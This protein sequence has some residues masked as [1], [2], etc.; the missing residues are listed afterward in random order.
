MISLDVE[1]HWGVRDKRTVAQYERNLRGDREAVLA[2]LNAFVEV[3]IPATW[4]VVGFLFCDGRDE[5]RSILPAVR[6]NYRD[7]HLSPYGDI[8]RIGSDERS[9]PFH[10]APSLIRRIVEAP[11]Q[12][13]ATHTL[14]HY[15][16]LAPGGTL[17][18][19]E[20]DLAAAIELAR[21]KF[22]RTIQSIVFPR[23]QYDHDHLVACRRQNI[24]AYRGNEASWIYRPADR[25]SRPKR[26]IRLVDSFINLTGH[27]TSAPFLQNREEPVNIPSSRFLRPA[28]RSDSVPE[29]LRLRRIESA[30][31]HAARNGQVF[32]L[33]WHPHNFGGDVPR[34]MR[35]L[36]R[37]LDHYRRLSDTYGMGARSMADVARQT[38]GAAD[39]A[40]GAAG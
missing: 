34:N 21:C 18:A 30:M 38:L 14:S 35:I 28:G 31:T 10:F 15:Y 11:G 24:I 33:W 4:A 1:L 19:F 25:E 13:L 2:M 20:A 32:H 27:H 39:P 3:G 9:A 6:P 8:E 5:L 36:Q 7:P 16:C 12:E 40:I 37:L 22:S 23:N 26:A 29:Q 17:E